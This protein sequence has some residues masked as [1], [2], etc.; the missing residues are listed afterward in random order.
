MVDV[1][2]ATRRARAVVLTVSPS[3]FPFYP[4]SVVFQLIVSPKWSRLESLSQRET[5]ACEL[6]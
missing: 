6:S 5:R 3:F 1:C 2:R 4:S